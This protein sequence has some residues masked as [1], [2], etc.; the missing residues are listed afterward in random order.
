[1]KPLASFYRSDDNTFVSSN[2]QTLQSFI[3][4]LHKNLISSAQRKQS[5]FY[6]EISQMFGGPKKKYNSVQ[7]A[8]DDMIT[9]TGLQTHLQNISAQ[10]KQTKKVA[11]QELFA[12]LKPHVRE[13]IFHFIRN[14]ISDSQGEIAIPALQDEILSLFR[15]EGVLTEDVYSEA[16][17]RFI[18]QAL[19]AE[20][21]KNPTQ[22]TSDPNLG[23]NLHHDLED[24]GSNSDFFRSLNPA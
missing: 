24:D 21:I 19:I 17:A 22:K 9:R 20:K 12:S 11:Q 7:A 16:T 5:G 15:N 13:N 3:S 4:N 1:M 2:P 8:V 6:E 23:K 10:Q 18:N 14:K